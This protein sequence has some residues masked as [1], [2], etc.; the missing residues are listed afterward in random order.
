MVSLCLGA[1]FSGSEPT[2]LSDPR[3]SGDTALF[4]TCSARN[5]LGYPSSVWDV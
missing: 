2:E 5:D 3:E 1:L 4:R